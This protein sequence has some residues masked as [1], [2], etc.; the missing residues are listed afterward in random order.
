MMARRR[1]KKERSDR[2]KE[3]NNNGI[4]F[5]KIVKAIKWICILTILEMIR[6]I[7]KTIFFFVFYC[8]F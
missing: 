2:E 5:E 1:E 3:G 6:E 8:I 7:L 4:T